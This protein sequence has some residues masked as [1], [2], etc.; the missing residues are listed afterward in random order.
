M[1]II[2]NTLTNSLMCAIIKHVMKKFWRGAILSVFAMLLGV[3]SLSAPVF[4]DPDPT[5]TTPET[6]VT[7]PGETTPGTTTT[8]PATEEEQEAR[9]CAKQAGGQAWFI[10]QGT[11]TL[12]NLIDGAYGF[13]DYLIRVDPLPTEENAPFRIVWNYFRVIT[14][15]LFA[16]VLLICI[17]SQITGFGINNYGIKRA[18]P[19]LV[20]IAIAANLSYIICQVAVDLSNI[21]GNGLREVFIAIENQAV[22]DGTINLESGVNA[23]ALVS[24]LLGIGVTAIIGGTVFLAQSGGFTGIMWLILPVLLSGAIAVISAIIT[25]AARQALI[26]LLTMIS[27]LAIIAYALPNTES[28]AKKWYAMFLKMLIFF[29]MFSVLYGASHLAGFVIMTSAN[30]NDER[31]TLQLVIGFAVQILPLFMSI[32]LMRMSKTILGKVSDIMNK[33]TKPAT[34]SFEGYANARRRNAIARQRSGFGRGAGMPHNRLAQYMERRRNEITIDTALHERT[35]KE[36]GEAAYYRGARNRNG[37]Y[38]RRGATYYMMQENKL[39]NANE[40]MEFDTKM[41]SGLNENEVERGYSN[42]VRQ[43]NAHLQE[44]VTRKAIAQARRND[45]AHRNASGAATRIREALEDTGDAQG[46]LGNESLRIRNMVAQSFGVNPGDT[47]GFE[48]A[49][50]ILISDAIA[51]RRKVDSDSVKRH[52][53]R[54]AETR[55]GRGIIDEVEKTLGRQGNGASAR[56]L[57]AEELAAFKANA[58]NIDY[59]VIDA[60]MPEITKRGDHGDIMEI[61]RNYSGNIKDDGDINNPQDLKLMTVQ[62]HLVD[63]VM[64]LKAENE[65][66][67]AWSKANNIRRSMHDQGMGVEGYIS[68]EDFIQNHRL[69]GDTDDDAYRKVGRTFLIA[70]EKNKGLVKTQDRTVFKQALKYKKQGILAADDFFF[71]TKD[72][73][74][75]ISSGEMDG[76]LLNNALRFITNGFDKG[77]GDMTTVAEL[78][79]LAD[80]QDQYFKDN[81]QAAYEYIS[82]IVGGMSAKQL[83]T[84]KSTA[85]FTLS[86]MLASIDGRTQNVTYRDDKGNVHHEAMSTTFLELLNKNHA[87]EELRSRSNSS[88]RSGMNP[89]VAKL[90][91]VLDPDSE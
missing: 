53:D 75:S 8:T 1:Y 65:F 48:H 34:S 72:V 42:M 81:K 91:G 73:R 83:S 35:S 40:R 41:D 50:S 18:L 3:F 10:C 28:W 23:S 27:P 16:I 47:A 51:D 44:D 19:R 4:A 88:M 31:Y 25:M 9:S 78:Q 77:S 37:R 86:R 38:N 84:S 66:V 2:F 87:I 22:A 24:G 56:N 55:A 82:E 70:D 15:S 52:A 61:L 64:T 36:G 21:L 49:R 71:D 30:V 89:V 90:V 33:I 74:G 85:I 12:A 5:T 45:V 32:P 20:I 26:Y 57:N 68:F 11:G 6:T 43:V 7:T 59:S 13:L 46:N 76:E 80:S 14:N 29:P 62:K 17:F 39:H 79:A 60:A 58:G 67:S 63:S 54:F 69:A